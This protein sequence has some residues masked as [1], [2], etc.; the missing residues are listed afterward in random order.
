M[1]KA[2]HAA[3]KDRLP[4][5]GV[6][7]KYIDLRPSSGGGMIG[8]CPF[9]T[10]SKPSFHVYD[11]GH[12]HCFG[13]QANGDVFTFVMEME[14][15]DFPMARTELAKQA[16]ISLDE[17]QSFGI[18]D[19][20]D[21]FRK[22]LNL[23][24]SHFSANIELKSLKAQDYID[25]RGIPEHLVHRFG[26]GFAQ[27]TWNGLCDYLKAQGIASID[28]LDLG[29][30]QQHKSSGKIY[31]FF[32]NR[33]IFPI[34]NLSGS[35]CGFGGRAIDGDSGPKYVNSKESPVF[36]KGSELYGIF[37]ARKA[38]KDIGHV[39]LVEGYTDN[40]SMVKHGFQNTCAYL[41]TAFTKNHAQRL[42]TVTSSVYAYPDGDAAGRKSAVLISQRVILEGLKCH[43]V[44]L[45]DGL[46]VD[47]ILQFPDGA[48]VLKG[49]TQKARPGFTVIADHLETLSFKER[50]T[51]VSTFL[52]GCS[53]QVIGWIVPKLSDS[54]GV[55]EVE[56][57]KLVKEA[58]DMFE[59]EKTILSFA[60]S[61]PA[62]TEAMQRMGVSE[63]LTTDKARAHWAKVVCREPI[64][65]VPN[66]VMTGVEVMTFW[67]QEIL[68][69]IDLKEAI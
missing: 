31:D 57:R 37:Q 16:G 46:D 3:I 4:L 64:D 56:L 26:I 9:H 14:N 59:I 67:K 36:Q 66:L 24:Q 65:S 49:L 41:G 60:Q 27:N 22:V 61:F 43:I 1:S 5:A 54:I 17:K 12:Y 10:D 18:N 35:I 33:L 25:E 34:H 51:W 7:S 19:R 32:R 68:P 50:S 23:S 44:D 58:D 39:S 21:R 11:D 15:W 8:I 30:V 28:A 6:V 63:A 62:Y 69:L 48:D 13:C 20:P 29:V 2:L 40:L 53:P 52:Q 38:I 55:S 47:E 45:P 42:S